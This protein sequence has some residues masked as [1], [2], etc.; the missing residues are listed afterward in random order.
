MRRALLP[1]LS[2]LLLGVG[3]A[4]RAADDD[5]KAIIAKAIKAHGGEEKLNKY[6]AIQAR[7]KGKADTPVGE[8]EFTHETSVML[9]DKFKEVTELEVMG[10][11]LRIV[12]LIVGDKVT[13]EANGEKVDLP[14]KAI[15]VLKETAYQ[16]RVARL[17][18]LLKEKEF[19]LSTLGESKV[20]GK[21]AVGV[22]V[23]SKGHSDMNLYFDKGTGLIAKVEKRSADPMSGNEFTEER[24]IIEYQKVD[25]MP[26]PKKV[27]INHDGKKAVEVEVD[28]VK[29]LEK[30]DDSEFKK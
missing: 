13:I 5:V 3:P 17:V 28:E 6:K 7:G 16:T 26:V 14:D 25:G 22:L 2:V 10:K 19:E 29:Q 27:V 23:K 18:P 15:D 11:K 1:V 30:L 21:P 4:A 8:I 24:I 9:P 12:T 20:N